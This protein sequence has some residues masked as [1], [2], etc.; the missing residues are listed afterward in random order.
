ML[1]SINLDFITEVKDGILY[2]PLLNN[3]FEFRLSHMLKT[4]HLAPDD[5]LF[6]FSIT[7]KESICVYFG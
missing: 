2:Y 3:V 7:Y 5:P 4:F 6:I 1:I